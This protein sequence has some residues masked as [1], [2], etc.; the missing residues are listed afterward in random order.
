M[1]AIELGK[2]FVN[3]VSTGALVAAYTGRGRTRAKSQEGSVERF[4]GGRFRSISTEGVAG[5]QTFTLRDVS[6]ADLATLEG[7]IGEL[8]LVR[9]NRGRRMFG[10]YYQV[11]YAD[12]PNENYY[13]VELNVLEVSYNE[14]V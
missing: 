12:R 2:T 4:A 9:D 6:P 3:L 8:V 13:D 10:T 7:W 1:V 5:S 11:N 14:G